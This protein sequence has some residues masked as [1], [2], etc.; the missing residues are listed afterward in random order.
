MQL[1]NLSDLLL[2]AKRALESG[3]VSDA[4]DDLVMAQDKKAEIEALV[5]E[6]MLFH[7]QI[8]TSLDCYDFEG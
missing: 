6:L 2:N 7:A 8:A 3:R 5:E 1:N 4:Q